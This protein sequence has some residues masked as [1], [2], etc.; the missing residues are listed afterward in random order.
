MGKKNY[1]RRFYYFEKLGVPCH[2]GD[3]RLTEPENVRHPLPTP[4]S[5]R[6]DAPAHSP[7]LRSDRL[8][9]GH[10]S[11][12]GASWPRGVGWSSQRQ[13]SAGR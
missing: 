13:E 2:T 8:G 4:I 6:R 10:M 7:W 11:P 5:G 9:C 3:R 12:G 1:K